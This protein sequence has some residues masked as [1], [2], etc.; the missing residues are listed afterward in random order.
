MDG[1]ITAK[2]TYEWWRSDETYERISWAA[3]F[4]MGAAL[5]LIEIFGITE[6]IGWYNGFD[7]FFLGLGTVM[8]LSSIIR[9]TVLG[10][11]IEGMGA[12][13]GL[14]LISIG[15]NRIVDMVLI[16]PI[17]LIIFGILILVSAL[18]RPK[19]EGDVDDWD[20]PN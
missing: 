20:M 5:L 11:R 8:V 1:K 19:F 17:L 13:C 16:W 4:F 2:R 9:R 12:V 10:R 18:L 14:I 7:L 3:I 15:I 6:D